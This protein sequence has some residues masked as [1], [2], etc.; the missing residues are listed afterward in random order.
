MGTRADGAGSA[1]RDGLFVPRT[2]IANA[3]IW[4]RPHSPNVIPL[5]QPYFPPFAR[6]Y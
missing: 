3:H 1:R 2:P 4:V 5:A 6:S